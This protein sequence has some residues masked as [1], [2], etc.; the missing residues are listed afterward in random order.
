M[1]E[2]ERDLDAAVRRRDRLQG[3]IQKA[4]GRLE[5]ARKA[6]DSIVEE[7]REND[8][9]PKKIDQTIEALE[10]GIR[11]NLSVINEQLDQVEEGIAPFLEN[12]ED[13]E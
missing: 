7:C 10:R 12:V 4:K 8:V 13:S 3:E 2:L 9:D 5:S 1:D 6:V 11:D